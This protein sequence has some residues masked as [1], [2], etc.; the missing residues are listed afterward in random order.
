M[1]RLDTSRWRESRRYD[2]FD[3]L[4]VEGLAWECLRRN[5]DYQNL[6]RN[7]GVVGADAIPLT[8]EAERRW[9]LRFRRRSPLI[10]ESTAC[11]VVGGQQSGGPDSDAV[12]RFSKKP[13]RPSGRRR[14][15]RRIPE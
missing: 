2:Y 6:F 8:P 11:P 13:R 10:G 1:M 12:S 15:R 7:L 9:G 14:R 4:S 3:A 5:Q